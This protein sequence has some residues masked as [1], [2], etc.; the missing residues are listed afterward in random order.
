M[1]VKALH[2]SNRKE[3]MEEKGKEGNIYTKRREGREGEREGGRE[4]GRK[5]MVIQKERRKENMSK[6]GKEGRSNFGNCKNQHTHARKKDMRIKGNQKDTHTHAKHPPSPAFSTASNLT[7]CLRRN[8]SCNPCGDRRSV[9]SGKPEPAS[10]DPTSPSSLT[11]A[12]I[13][14]RSTR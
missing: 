1:Q 3:G 10:A 7:V 5:D 6:K 8:Q 14:R 4:G 13:D 11:R 9:H 12:R 2:R